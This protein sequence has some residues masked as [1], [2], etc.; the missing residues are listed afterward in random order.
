M[1]H[2][3]KEIAQAFSNGNF[4]LT[5]PYL[6]ESVIWNVVGENLFKGK[7]E[8]INNCEQTA[9]YFKS[10]ET[11]FQTEDSIVA[12]NKVIIRGTGEFIREGKRVNLITA[13][14]VY[15]FNTNGDLE[16][17]SSYCI[18]ENK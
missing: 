9:E 10:V 12:D 3:Q 15:E 14:D 18:P 13:C 17:I 6:S 4:E 11:N 16:K 5:F 7:S 1:E 8:V 2:T